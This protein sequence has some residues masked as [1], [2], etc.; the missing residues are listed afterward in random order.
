MK[1]TLLSLNVLFFFFLINILICCICIILVNNTIQSV[2]FL[3]LVFCNSSGVLL[4]LNCD[5]LAFL[6]IIIYVGAVVVL[7]LFVIMMLKVNITH[8]YLGESFSRYLPLGFLINLIVL[9]EFFFI[10]SE[11]YNMN[12]FQVFIEKLVEHKFYVNWFEIFFTVENIKTVSTLVLDYFWIYLIISSIILMIA[13]IGCIILTIN[14]K[15]IH[16]KSQIHF[17]KYNVSLKERISLLN[18]KIQ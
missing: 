10:Y 9:L 15:T 16:W 7:F 4:L 6:L 1:F 12:N 5:F 13:M 14:K 11:N 17:D 8:S 3:I 18:K 2:F